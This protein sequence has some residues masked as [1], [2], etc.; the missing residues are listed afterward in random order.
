M[1]F[2]KKEEVGKEIL[3]AA[4]AAVEYYIKSKEA[5]KKEVVEAAT[6]VP[7]KVEELTGVAP[8]SSWVSMWRYEVSQQ[9]CRRGGVRSWRSIR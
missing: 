6:L 7:P 4:V 1:I 2:K 3:A 5:K 8:S 9:L